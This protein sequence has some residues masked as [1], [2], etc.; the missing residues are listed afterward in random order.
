MKLSQWLDKK[1]KAKENWQVE[2]VR[3]SGLF[4]ERW[5]VRQYQDVFKKLKD[6]ARH[7]CLKG[8]KENRNPSEKFETAAYLRK[9]PECGIC[10]LVFERNRNDKVDLVVCAIVKDEAPYIKEWIDYH[11][12][13]GV[14]RFYIY[15]NDSSDN[16][17][18]VL[19]PYIRQGLVIYIYY[20]GKAK[21][22]P[23]YNEFIKQYGEKTEWVAFIDIDE[24]VIPMQN[25]TIPEFLE[26]YKE[27]PGVCINWVSYDSNGHK[28]Q[29]KGG[30]LQSY[31]RV[32][33]DENLV[34]FHLIKSIVQPGRVSEIIN[35]HF[36]LYKN[37]EMAVNENK[38][39]VRGDLV[40]R[41]YIAPYSVDKIRINHYYCKSAQEAEAKVIRGT[42][43][44]RLKNISEAEINFDD[45]KYDYTAYKFV[46]QLYP[47]IEEQEELR[48]A[49]MRL[50]NLF[51]K[52]KHLF[53]RSPL[54]DYIDE[55]WYFAR[56]PDAKE[57]GWSAAKHYMNVG[58]RKG[59]NPSEKFDTDFYLHQYK[60]VADKR[61]NPLLH[62]IGS[63]K[64]EGRKALP[65][66]VVVSRS[67]ASNISDHVTSEK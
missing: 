3:K 9:Y 44:G 41:A 26:D 37:D 48:I 38:E 60:D 54:Y 29:P 64:K 55:E 63:G 49:W 36:A 31:T 25:A 16:L 43:E 2:I 17:K 13:V 46:I 52:V 59:Y 62:Y 35:P 30:V 53:I 19:L 65:K 45:Y 6:P 61:V 57:S 12:M 4:D 42:P 24:F 47:E 56:Y 27:Y 10:P 14:K 40:E 50:K 67:T 34:P 7:Y 33:Y 8:W 21:Q 11:L 15:D 22:M 18:Q 5:Y 58:W 51:L 32:H 1:S 20:P 66:E 28:K 39:P 23:C